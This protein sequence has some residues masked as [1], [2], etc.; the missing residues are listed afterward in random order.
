L[1]T[2]KKVRRLAELYH[3]LREYKRLKTL[4]DLDFGQNRKGEE[5]E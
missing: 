2:L 3:T 4:T 5:V 1:S